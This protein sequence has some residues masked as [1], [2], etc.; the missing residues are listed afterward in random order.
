MQQSNA[1]IIKAQTDLLSLTDGHNADSYLPLFIA[2]HSTKEQSS[3]TKLPKS[4]I[5]QSRVKEN[6]LHKEPCH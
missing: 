3:Q 2:P 1:S 5:S 6:K 4:H